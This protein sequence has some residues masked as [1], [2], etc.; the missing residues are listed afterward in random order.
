MSSSSDRLPG[1]AAAL[2]I[3]SLLTGCSRSEPCFPLEICNYRD[4]DCNGLIDEQFK[5]AQGRYASLH[6]C[7]ACEVDC[8]EAFPSALDVEC[9]TS[10]P[11]P[12]CR[13]VSCPEGMHPAG[14]Q[15]CVPDLDPLCLPCTEDAECSL[16]DPRAWCEQVGMSL[17]C[18]RDCDSAGCPDGFSCSAGDDGRIGCRPE[19]G[20]CSCTPASAGIAYGCLLEGA[21]GILCTGEMLCEGFEMGP[22]ESLLGE[23]C[24]G[25]DNDCDMSVDEDFLTADGRFVHP[26]HCGACNEPCVAPGPNMTA[27]CSDTPAPACV[28]ECEEGFV[29]LDLVQSNGCECEH[30]VGTWPPS[31]LGVDADC[32]GIIDDSDDFIFVTTR[33]N[34]SSPGTLVFPMRTLPAAIARAATADK[35]V[36]VASGSYLGPVVLSAGVDVFGGYSGDF[37]DRA[38]DLYPTIVSNTGGEGGRPVLRASGIRTATRVGGFTIIGSDASFV[39]TGS[40]TVLLTGCGA[41]LVLEDMLV[42]AGRGAHGMDGADSSENLASWGMTSLLDLNGVDGSPGRDGREASSANCTGLV[43]N[44]GAPGRRFCPGTGST[45]DGGEGG[46]TTCPH[47]G[48]V[49]GLPCANAGCTDYTVGGVCDVDAVF[50]DAVPNPAAGDGSGPSGGSAG[51]VTYDPPTNRATCSFCDDSPPLPREGQD[52]ALG[53]N[54]ANGSGGQACTDSMGIF[55]SSS[56]RWSA[57]DGSD[58]GNGGEGSGGGGGT[59]GSG[60]DVIVGV[61]GCNDVLGGSGGGGGSGGCGAPWASG[62]Q[63]GGGSIAIA[64]ILTP[65]T[66]TG[67]SFSGVRVITA[68]AGDG[69]D[70]GIGAAG[71]SGGGGATGGW[72]NFWCA[73]RGGRG[74]D[75][76]QGGAGGGGGGGCGGSVSGVHIVST[77]AA[78]DLYRAYVE[79]NVVVASLASEGAGGSGGFSP[80]LVG[81]NGLAGTAI[82]VRLVY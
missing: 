11:F 53:G 42:Q 38:P 73:R 49:T 47:T 5:D 54:G 63:G 60:Y 17:R 8:A 14:D 45:L 66:T 24:D 34:D 58:G 27:T 19:S 12:R 35:T 32:D 13:L 43:I 40:T 48:C 64:V 4:D 18:V 80:G 57:G 26:D 71:G 37:S 16:F 41:E 25:F 68:A 69:G 44:G 51:A 81:G 72:G 31:R 28:I 33:G 23:L 78:A 1:M 46:D 74:G 39:G 36:L 75:G 21:D 10:G 29:D 82:E 76:G 52:G 65:G 77:T 56:G 7:G 2:I 61:T 20:E 70:G 50:A 15:A 6:H 62:G 3:L 30:N 59:C 22:C 55:D 9:D 67:P 79:S